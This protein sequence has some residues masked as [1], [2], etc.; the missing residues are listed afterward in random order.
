MWTIVAQVVLAWAL[1][2]LVGRRLGFLI[3]AVLR[4]LSW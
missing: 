3:R 4:M 1:L 2:Q